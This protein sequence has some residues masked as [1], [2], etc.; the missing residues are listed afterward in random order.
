MEDYLDTLA[1]AESIGGLEELIARSDRN[2]KAVSDWVERTKW[3]DFLAV[4]AET[5][6]NTSVCL[7]VVEPEISSR[8][9]EEQAAFVGKM[10]KLLE[11]EGVAFDIG[12]YRDAPPGLR[13]WCGATVE[14]GDLEAL[15]PWLDWAF[16]TLRKEFAASTRAA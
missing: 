5:R 12:A 6:S 9:H 14:T 16:A 15:F 4:E 1:W 2:A 8:P 10:V 11:K 7:R 3:V 13:L